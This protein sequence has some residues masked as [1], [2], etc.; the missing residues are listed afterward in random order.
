MRQAEQ[1]LYLHVASLWLFRTGLHM[2]HTNIPSIT[3]SHRGF[4]D[5][6]S[7]QPAVSCSP[8]G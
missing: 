8:T 3:D 7:L 5:P 4:I 2:L 6:G 1:L